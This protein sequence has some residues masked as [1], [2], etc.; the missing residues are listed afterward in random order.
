MIK[1]LV[2]KNIIPLTNIFL[3]PAEMN[4]EI[5]NVNKILSNPTRRVILEPLYQRNGMS[6]VDIRQVLGQMNTG[7]LNYHLKVLGDLITKNP[8]TGKYNLTE[9]GISA[10]KMNLIPKED[11]SGTDHKV[12]LDPMG[13]KGNMDLSTYVGVGATAFIVLV[14]T[15]YQFFYLHEAKIPSLVAISALWFVIAFFTWRGLSPQSKVGKSAA[16]NGRR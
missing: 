5:C 4:D 10:L 2:R 6:Y 14:A 15:W 12:S 7:Q 11:P 16:D 1:V 13:M 3:G 9:D 8:E